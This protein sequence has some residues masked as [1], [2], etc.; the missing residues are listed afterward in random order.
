MLKSTAG[1]IWVTSPS[2]RC[3]LI[4]IMNPFGMY[5]GSSV[6]TRRSSRAEPS[7]DA[8]IF[9]SAEPVIVVSRCKKYKGAKAAASVSLHVYNHRFKKARVKC[10]PFFLQLTAEEE[11]VCLSGFFSCFASL[12]VLL[13]PKRS[14][15]YSKTHS[16]PLSCH[17]TFFHLAVRVCL[18]LD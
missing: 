6:T 18:F 7:V 2:S 13:H 14:V 16:T 15:E 5:L 11:M 3:D 17:Q 12:W 1:P 9:P 8:G 4:S 10:V